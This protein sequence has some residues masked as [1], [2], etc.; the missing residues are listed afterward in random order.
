MSHEHPI[1]YK[2]PVDAY[3]A[4]VIEVLKNTPDPANLSDAELTGMIELFV[5]VRDDLDEAVL[6]VAN[7]MDSRGIEDEPV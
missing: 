5:D 6:G 3:R 1:E 7:E 4:Q 2:S